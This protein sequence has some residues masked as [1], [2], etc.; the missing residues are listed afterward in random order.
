MKQL[1][2]VIRGLMLA[3]L[4]FAGTLSLAY[5]HGDAGLEDGTLEVVLGEWSLGFKTAKVDAGNL[6]IRVANGGTIAHNL[7]VT[8]AGA[9][10]EIYKTRLLDPGETAELALQFSQDQYDLYCSVPG[11]RERGMLAALVVGEAAPR[12][13]PETL[14][15]GGYY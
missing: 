12:K 8:M 14:G 6:P 5:A 13:E 7:T 2:S 1:S 3:P 10:S 15:D 11:H 4:I 9:T